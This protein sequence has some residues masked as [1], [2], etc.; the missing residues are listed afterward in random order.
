MARRLIIDSLTHL[1]EV[2]GVDGF[3]FDLGELLGVDVLRDVH[4][5][6]HGGGDGGG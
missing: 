2:Y 3:R 1:V 6:W 5:R 4:L